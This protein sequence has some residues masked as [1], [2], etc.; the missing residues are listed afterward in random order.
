MR[1]AALWVLLGSGALLVWKIL[2]S[3]VKDA[4]SEPLKSALYGWLDSGKRE[5]DFFMLEAMGCGESSSI[6]GHPFTLSQIEHKLTKFQIEHVFG[7]TPQIYLALVKGTTS[8][9]ERPMQKRRRQ[10]R[11]WGIPEPQE[12]EA[13]RLKKIERIMRDMMHRGKLKYHPPNAYAII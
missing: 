12:G 3:L 5:R 9:D 6:V 2:P 7:G 11:K 4:L 8:E 13:V 10:L 1:P